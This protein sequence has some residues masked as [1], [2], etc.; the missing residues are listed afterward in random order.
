MVKHDEMLEALDQLK[1]LTG[2]EMF[3]NK[4]V[5]CPWSR[6]KVAHTNDVQTQPPKTQEDT[7]TN[8]VQ[9]QPSKTQEETLQTLRNELDV[10]GAELH[11]K[12]R[13]QIQRDVDLT[14]REK[15]LE[16]QKHTQTYTLQTEKAKIQQE[17]VRINTTD[18]VLIVER[19]RLSNWKLELDMQA[20]DVDFRRQTIQQREDR[21]TV[22]EE[23]HR[24]L[25]ESLVNL[26]QSLDLARISVEQEKKKSEEWT[27]R[28]EYM[29]EDAKITHSEV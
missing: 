1:M 7:H 22:K 12:D 8:D 29:D 4:E 15:L 17:Y 24:D 3:E 5:R 27:K 25:K 21:V 28:V 16:T 14:E 6:S 11:E 26:T 10:F 9:T 20:K 18:N 2:E 13:R 23:R 19:N